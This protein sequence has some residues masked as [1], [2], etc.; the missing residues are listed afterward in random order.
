MTPREGPSV[1][2]GGQSWRH[3]KDNGKAFQRA[4]ERLIEVHRE[5]ENANPILLLIIHAAIAYGDALT[6]RFGG[7]TNRKDH[8]QLPKLIANC[9]GNRAPDEQIKRLGRILADKDAVAYGA[10]IGHIEPART[11]LEQ[12]DRFSRWADGALSSM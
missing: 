4:A 7:K 1:T 6:D 9:M 8:Q 2:T 10:R 3:R 11:M 5:G 12:L